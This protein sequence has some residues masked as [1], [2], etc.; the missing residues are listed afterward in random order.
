MVCLSLYDIKS[1]YDVSVTSVFVV[2]PPN[3]LNI[4]TMPLASFF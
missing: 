2:I 4:I 3:I 1:K